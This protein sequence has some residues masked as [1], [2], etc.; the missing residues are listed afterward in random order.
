MDDASKGWMTPTEDGRHQKRMDDAKKGWMTPTKDGRLR[1]EMDRPGR[2]WKTP[3]Q[4]MDDASSTLRAVPGMRCAAASLVSSTLRIA[5]T[6][7]E[8]K[9]LPAEG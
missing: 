5:A 2:G 9:L 8:V 3:W 4:E 7:V 1:Q 6:T